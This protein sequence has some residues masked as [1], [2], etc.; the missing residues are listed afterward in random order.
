MN[1]DS[2][3]DEHRIARYCKPSAIAPNGLPMAAAFELRRA[4][5]CLSVNWIEYFGTED[6]ELAL[7][8][9]RS[10]FRRKSFRLGR[11][12]KFAILNVGVVKSVVLEEAGCRPRIEHQ[13]QVDDE[14]HSGVCGYAEASDPEVNKKVAL[15][16][17]M[18][19]TDDDLF[20]ARGA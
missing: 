3:P 16:I 2:L 15:G 6:I 17:R 20:P 7:D 12:G 11:G 5:T 19:L 10:A 4:E 8:G 9:V 1:G 13:P 18:K 14:S